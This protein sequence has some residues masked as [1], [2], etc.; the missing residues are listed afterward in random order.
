MTKERNEGTWNVLRN[1]PHPGTLSIVTMSGVD[2]LP[3]SGFP[4]GLWPVVKRAAQGLRD[5]PG[6]E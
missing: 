3:C 2:A 5:K 6:S 1:R 4:A